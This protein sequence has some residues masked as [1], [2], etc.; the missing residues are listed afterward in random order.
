M[1]KSNKNTVWAIIYEP[2]KEIFSQGTATDCKQRHSGQDKT[3]ENW[4]KN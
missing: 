1:L 3:E 4:D 2:T